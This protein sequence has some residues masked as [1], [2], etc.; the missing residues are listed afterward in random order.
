MNY[1]LDRSYSKVSENNWGA[2][3]KEEN[4]SKTI[5]WLSDQSQA[6]HPRAV[7]LQPTNQTSNQTSKAENNWFDKHENEYNHF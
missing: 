3:P 4:T 2:I 5:D 7:R 1:V 6:T